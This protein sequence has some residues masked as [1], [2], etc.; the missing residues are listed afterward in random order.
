MLRPGIFGE[1]DR[2][3]VVHEGDQPRPA[4]RQDP[5]H[6]LAPVQVP[7]RDEQ[8]DRPQT[9]PPR[10]PGCRPQDGLDPD[11]AGGGA[12]GDRPR[13]GAAPA[14]A[15]GGDEAPGLF[16]RQDAQPVQ[17]VDGDELQPLGR[18]AQ[19]L[20]GIGEL[21]PVDPR[22]C[23]ALRPR[24]QARH[25][26]QQGGAGRAA[27]SPVGGGVGRIGVRHRADLRHVDG[28]GAATWLSSRT[29]A[30]A[31][32]WA[33]PCSLKKPPTSMQRDAITRRNASNSTGSGG[34]AS[35]QKLSSP[36]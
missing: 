36:A 7:V 34:A 30:L 5:R 14:V 27:P 19:Q 4:G 11:H 2:D 10:R 18:Q 13:S 26:Q 29:T 8:V 24:Q 1:L 3:Q 9:L 12:D 31:T 21:H 33:I 6:P 32:N 20:L 28:G 25:V 22:G 17:L 23:A 16:Q 15:H 35:V